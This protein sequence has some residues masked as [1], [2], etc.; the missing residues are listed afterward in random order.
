MLRME[1]KIKIFLFGAGSSIARKTFKYKN[2]YEVIGFAKYSNIKKISEY[3]VYKYKSLNSFRK[4]ADK[5]D[6]DKTVLIFFNT[7][8]I[9]NLI[10]NKDKKEIIKEFE[11]NVLYPHEIIKNILPTMI[12]KR[13]GRIIFLGS[14]RALKSDSGILGYSISKHSLLAYSKTL[15]KEYAKLG[16]TSNYISLGLFDS[17]LLKKVKKNEFNNIIRNTDT[18]D[19]GDFDSLFNAIDFIINSKYV[20][21]SIIPVDGGFN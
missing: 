12:K 20:T 15:S 1:L 18:R 14:S 7:L 2:N 5:Y 3:K 19:I 11:D 4:I 9:S 6:S 13:W 8:S 16:I 10:I 17:P 21:G